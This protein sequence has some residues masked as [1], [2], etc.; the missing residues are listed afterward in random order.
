MIF[1]E[2]KKEPK[3]KKYEKLIKYAIEKSDVMM[4]VVRRDRYINLIKYETIKKVSKI[5][6]KEVEDI[7]KNYKKYIKENFEKL[8]KNYKY[9]L[10]EASKTIAIFAEI[11]KKTIEEEFKKQLISNIKVEIE[12]KKE[13][14]IQEKNINELKEKLSRYLIKETHDSKWTV[15]EVMK[16]NKKENNKY[17]F[18]VC[19]YR[20]CPEIEKFLLESA[21]SLY[22]FK[23]PYFPE[24]I[25]FYKDEYCWF[26]TITHEKTSGMY[27]DSEEDCK[28]IENM[29]IKIKKYKINK[30]K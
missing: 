15:Q 26:Y 7:E 3:E 17:L 9:I 27:I 11:D 6:N 8:Y 1:C 28:R 5:I 18:D 22:S 13:F 16:R 30:K 29:G 20:T 19:F 4:F 2:I 14:I 12:G 21:K 24:D 25:A 23:P 10:G